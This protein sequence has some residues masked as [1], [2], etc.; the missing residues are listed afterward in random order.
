[1]NAEPLS[2]HVTFDDPEAIEVGDLRIVVDEYVATLGGERLDLTNKEFALL[3]LFARNRGRLLTREQ[4]AAQAWGGH[5]PG[6]TID[7][8]VARLRSRLPP[9]AISTVIKVG[10]R[11]ELA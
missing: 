10:Y 1:M 11:F 3:V 9:G 4:I 5:A 7:I 6:R 8:H 2:A